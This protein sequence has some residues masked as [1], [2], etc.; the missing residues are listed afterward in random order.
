MRRFWFL[1]ALISVLVFITFSSGEVFAQPFPFLDG[2]ISGIVID[3]STGKPLENST[4][5]AGIGASM[6]QTVATN[7]SGQYYIEGLTGN[8]TGITYNVT[9]SKTGYTS[10][11]RNVILKTEVDFLP[12]ATQNFTLN[13]IPNVTPTPAVPELSSETLILAVAVL[14]I[15]SGNVFK[16]KNVRFQ[17]R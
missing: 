8:L 6:N 9:A 2:K 15:L 13:P 12:P 14:S 1:V 17:I 11:S 7:S 16:K 10:S 4:I 3:A 5:T